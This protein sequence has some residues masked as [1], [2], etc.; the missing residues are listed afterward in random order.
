MSRV[1]PVTAAQTSVQAPDGR[2]VDVEVRRSARRRRTVS[3]YRDGARVVV[4]LPARLPRADEEHWVQL[5]VARVVGRDPAARTS[6]DELEQRAQRLSARYLDGRAAPT[7]VRWVANQGRRWGSCTV[8]DGSIRLS[9]RLRSSPGWVVDYVLLHELAHL[10]EP[11]HGPD[12]WRLLA[13]YPRLER[14]R[15]YLEG[16]TAASDLDPG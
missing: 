8:E 15:G 13:G 4:L 14:A 6:D 10:I 3:A 12:F 11:A 16:F 5:M 7:S 2:T 9:H 1:P